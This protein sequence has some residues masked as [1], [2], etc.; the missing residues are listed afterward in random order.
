ML[1]ETDAGGEKDARRPINARGAAWAQAAAR[2]L[3]ARGV[4]PNAVSISSV[5]FGAGGCASL[6]LS[7]Y[8]SATWS[9]VLLILAP[10][11]IGLRSVANLLDGMIAVE[12]GKSTPAGILYNEVPDRISDALFFA[13]AAYAAG[14]TPGGFVLGWVCAVLAVFVTYT[15]VLG[16]SLGMAH[17]FRGPMAKPH[18]MAA[19]AVGCIA[20]AIERLVWGSAYAML[21][22][23][24][25]VALGCV[26]T[27]V[28]R[29]SA[30]ARH[31]EDAP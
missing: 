12:G 4:S 13:G 11:W 14:A 27:I 31:L 20:A 8:V 26:I 6:V 16:A 23:L 7:A 3:G 18:R 10:A 1:P 29:L 15:R 28:R 9:A 22:T 5:V 19:L 17:D 24:I 30:V 21:I 25:I 2:W